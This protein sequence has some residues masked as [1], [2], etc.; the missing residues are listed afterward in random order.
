MGALTVDLKY[1]PRQWQQQCHDDL[2]RFRVYALHRRAGKTVMAT[3]ELIYGALNCKEELGLFVF[4]APFLSQAKSIAWGMIKYR[5]RELATL[6]AIHINEAELTITFNNNGAKLKLYGADNPDALRGVRLDGAV[7][8]EVA[9]MKPEVW[10][11][12]VQPALSDRK[13]FA[14]FIGTPSGV[15]MFSEKFYKAKTL[16]NWSSKLFTV[17]DTDAIDPVEVERLK[18]DMAESSFAREYLCDFGAAGDDQL[19]SLNDIETA[20]K[21][22][23]RPNEFDY[24]PRIMGIDPAR[25]GDDSSVII[26]RQGFMMLDPIAF[27]G[28]DNMELADQSAYHINTWKPHAVF[29]DAGNGSGVIDRLRQIGHSVIEVPFGGKAINPKY[30]NKRAEMWDNLK[31]WLREGG[32]IP[33]NQRIKQDLGTPRYWFD[34]GNRM[35]LEPKDDIKARGLPSSDY[36]DAACLTFAMPVAVPQQTNNKPTNVEYEYNPLTTDAARGL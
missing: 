36:G 17:Y 27:H 20:S 12:I 1:K 30:A 2:A 15:N 33:N 7:L 5:L 21:R 25:F 4:I 29:I 34:K 32:C 13:G 23:Y 31:D 19:I 16:P 18:R 8:D 35:I 28:M 6:D 26:K 11:D 10:E 22:I 9:Q 3:M 14:I 24:A